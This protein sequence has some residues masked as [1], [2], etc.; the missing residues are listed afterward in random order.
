MFNPKYGTR[1][2]REAGGEAIPDHLGGQTLDHPDA[3][4]LG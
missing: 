3:P 4:V 1:E 2:V